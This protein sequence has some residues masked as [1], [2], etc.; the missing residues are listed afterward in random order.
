MINE[1]KM[2]QNFITLLLLNLLI[3]SC[4]QTKQTTNK[5]NNLTD[6][7]SLNHGYNELANPS[8]RNTFT[9]SDFNT[10]NS[11]IKN[12]Y[13]PK[14]ST[15]K[16]NI[17]TILLFGIW[18]SDPEGPHA[19]FELTSKSFY[20]VDYEGDGD[21]PYELND[22]NIKVYYND[23]IQE[24]KVISV[25]KDTL[26]IMWKELDFVNSYVKWRQ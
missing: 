5:T 13:R 12:I 3:I 14:P 1:K 18:T 4:N 20:V 25:S 11:E 9:I 8:N 7:D 16:T 15:I 17:D 10:D 23:F 24:G 2:K 6:K 19:D 21:M 22:R 26:K